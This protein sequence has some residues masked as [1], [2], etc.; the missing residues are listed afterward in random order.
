MNKFNLPKSVID[1]VNGI[2]SQSVK[3]QNEQDASHVAALK[4]KFAAVRP[5]TAEELA[6]VPA[7]AR[8]DQALNN[9]IAS[10]MQ[11]SFEE[12]K[13]EH[14]TAVQRIDAM[15]GRAGAARPVQ[16]AKAHTVPKTEKEKSLAALAEPKDKITHADVMTGRG[17]RKEE[18]EAEAEVVAEAETG[19]L[20]K[21]KSFAKKAAKKALETAGHGSDEQM[22]QDLRN[23]MYGKPVK[24]DI[25]Q[26]EEAR[27]DGSVFDAKVAKSFTKSKPGE[28]AGF[29]SK[30]VST[31]TVYTRKAKK[32]DDEK[33]MKEEVA[34]SAEESARLAEIAKGLGL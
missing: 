18:V 20:A 23:K 34:I 7:P 21:I 2:V 11:K 16:E 27:S 14:A 15:Y 13:N 26:V 10:I 5:L 25:A 4:S 19:A 33:E 31:G 30:K 1:S 8:K 22:K 9:S 6:D 12:S 29:D 3:Q 24:E 28:S 32:D 17:V